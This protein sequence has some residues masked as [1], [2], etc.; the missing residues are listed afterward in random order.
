MDIWRERCLF[1]ERDKRILQWMNFDIADYADIIFAV[2]TGDMSIEYNEQSFN[3]VGKSIFIAQREASL[4]EMN[5][6]I[7]ALEDAKTYWH[8]N[9][10]TIF[11]LLNRTINDMGMIK[12]SPLDTVTEEVRQ[13]T[14]N[15]EILQQQCK[16]LFDAANILI[17]THKNF[18]V[19]SL[20]TITNLYNIRL[21]KS[22]NPAQVALK[23]FYQA[24]EVSLL[25]E[26]QP[27]QPRKSFIDQYVNTLEQ[28]REKA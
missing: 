2:Q 27:D 6:F 17:N 7:K 9:F 22:T 5:I 14:H 3:N 15:Y 23:N 24:K 11:R 20:S 4:K 18:S 10:E 12:I 19:I 13:S 26:E 28:L 16:E 1:L 8:N 25:L 21:F